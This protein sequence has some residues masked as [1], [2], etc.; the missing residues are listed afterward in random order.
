MIEIVFDEALK[1]RAFAHAKK[2]CCKVGCYNCLVA[3]EIGKQFCGYEMRNPALADLN[4]NLARHKQPLIDEAAYRKILS[5][6]RSVW[7][8][9]LNAK[10]ERTDSTK[11][12]IQDNDISKRVVNPK[13]VLVWRGSSGG[14]GSEYNSMCAGDWE[15]VPF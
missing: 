12:I 2:L 6:A 9:A 7:M 1:A 13:S 5:I 11:K 8:D 15:S 3:Y 10:N 14:R 4:G